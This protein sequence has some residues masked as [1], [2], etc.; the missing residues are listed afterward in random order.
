[1]SIKQ[2]HL[3]IFEVLN[4]LKGFIYPSFQPTR[5][6]LKFFFKSACSILRWERLEDIIETKCIHAQHKFN[7]VKEKVKNSNLF[8]S[9]LFIVSSLSNGN[10][11][12]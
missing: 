2:E 1:M 12:V 9:V 5:T 8:P 10:S 11:K 7:V 6:S 4:L 3:N